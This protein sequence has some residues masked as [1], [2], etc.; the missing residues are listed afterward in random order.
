[1]RCSGDEHLAVFRFRK[2]EEPEEVRTE[3]PKEAPAEVPE[4][5]Q[6]PEAQA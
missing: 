3:A 5:S 6:E 4:E 2:V 1:M